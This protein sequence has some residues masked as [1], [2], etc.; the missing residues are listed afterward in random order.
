MSSKFMTAGGV[1]A[2][3]MI[4]TG[5][6]TGIGATI[7]IGAHPIGA[8]PSGAMSVVTGGRGVPKVGGSAV[9][10]VMTIET[11]PGSTTAEDR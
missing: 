7:A 6:A 5:G 9:N 3:M 2:G 11:C 10:G 4:A 1:I 8:H